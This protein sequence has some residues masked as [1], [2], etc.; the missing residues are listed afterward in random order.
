MNEQHRGAGPEPFIGQAGTIIGFGEFFHIA[1]SQTASAVSIMGW[2][3]NSLKDILKTWLFLAGLNGALALLAGAFAVHG[4]KARIAPDLLDAFDTGARYHMSHALAI[5]LAA[6]AGKGDARRS[7]A[8]SA[9]LFQA[10]IVMFSGSLY[11]LALT[12]TAGFAY[13]TPIGGLTLLAGWVALA[14][15]GLKL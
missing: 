12:G 11:L 6:I 9:G 14:M 2:R 5:G 4:L 1:Q 8:I 7:A 3:V 15:A 10:G 13:V